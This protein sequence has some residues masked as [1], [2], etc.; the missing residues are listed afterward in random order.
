M[1]LSVFDGELIMADAKVVVAARPDVDI[2]DD[3]EK[4]FHTYPPLAHDRPRI[5]YEV[6]DGVIHASGNVRTAQTIEIFAREAAKINGVKRVDTKKLYDD[7]TVWHKVGKKLPYGVY[8]SMSYGAVV[9]TGDAPSTEK[10]L[11]SLVKKIEKIAG[12]RK[13]IPN[14]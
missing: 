1:S 2:E 5:Q 13:V 3:L 11:A 12:V 8:S 14:F 9:L 10:K 6:K 7:D 4:V